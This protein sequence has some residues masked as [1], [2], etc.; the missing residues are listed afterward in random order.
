MSEAIYYVDHNNQALIGSIPKQAL[1]IPIGNVLDKKTLLSSLAKAGNFPAYFAHNW[2]SAWDCLT[3][4]DITY[5]T[6]Y[7][8]KVE[9][10][11]TEDFNVFKRIVEDAF[12]DFGKP[13]LWIIMASDDSLSHP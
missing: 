4:S 12:R 6:L 13:Q 1:N 11:N 8:N 2:D 5:L 9:K 7:L 10:L 3:D